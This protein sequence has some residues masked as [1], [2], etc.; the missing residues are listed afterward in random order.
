MAKERDRRD[1]GGVRA[2]LMKNLDRGY[3]ENRKET[4]GNQ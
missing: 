4:I 1:D 3:L 2:D